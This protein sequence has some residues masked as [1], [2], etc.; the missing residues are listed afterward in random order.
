MA[1]VSRGL[2]KFRCAIVSRLISTAGIGKSMIAY[3]CPR[4]HWRE[5]VAELVCR[6]VLVNHIR[7]QQLT[8]MDSKPKVAFAL[9]RNDVSTLELL[10]SAIT[11]ICRD[12]DRIPPFILE[13]QQR[14]SQQAREPT[15]EELQQCLSYLNEQAEPIF[16]FIDG[17]DEC[18]EPGQE[19]VLG[20]LQSLLP[21]LG[22]VRLFF[23][24]RRLNS[25]RQTMSSLRAKDLNLNLSPMIDSDIDDYVRKSVTDFRKQNR[26]SIQDPDLEFEIIRQLS[27]NAE[28]MCVHI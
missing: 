4:T 10:A 12:L 13:I 6:S 7:E 15:N 21:D 19:E 23:T 14:S 24:S 20:L 2:G 27:D 18:T 25:I 16:W 5:Q 8:T 22:H 17:L 3:V 28:K 1:S 26:L 9:L 11:Q